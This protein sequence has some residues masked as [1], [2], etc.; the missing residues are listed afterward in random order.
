[1]H[2]DSVIRVNNLTK[3]YRL[4]DDE[5]SVRALDGVDLS[6]ARG[7]YVALVGVS[8]S[9]KS[10]L[11]N[12]LGC[13]DRPTSGSYALNGAE[14]SQLSRDELAQVRN[15]DIGFV[16]QNFNLLPRA[17][18]L[19][20]VI[21][22]LRYRRMST[23]ER[24]RKALAMLEMVGLQDRAHHLPNQLSGGQRQRV[25]VA[26]ALVTEPRIILADEPTGNL[27]SRTTEDVMALFDSIN[28]QGQTIIVVT[29]EPAIAERCRRRIRLRD[30][31]IV[32]DEAHA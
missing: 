25:A 14:V 17:D 26:R 27:D 4:G 3:E 16:F 28:A 12:I 5:A 31:A 8:G 24:R 1:L 15:R 22:P 6:I 10:T 21:Q 20:N 19:A 11:M 13:L 18:A 30:G 9:G 2:A 7:E 29:H 23:I 32:S